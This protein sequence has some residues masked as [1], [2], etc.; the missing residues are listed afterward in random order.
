MKVH[1]SKKIND[2]HFIFISIIAI[3]ASQF[4]Q[5]F[6]FL[7]PHLLCLLSFLLIIIVIDLN[8]WMFQNLLQSDPGHRLYLQTLPN[9]ISALVC[10]VMSEVYLGRAD[11]F[12]LLEWDVSAHHVVQQDAQ[13]P[14]CGCWAV[15]PV[16]ADPFWRGVYSGTCNK[17]II[18]FHILF[19]LNYILFVSEIIHK[20]L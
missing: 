12:V 2:F 3:K 1:L 7:L 15:V 11:L 18:G 10:Q 9:K 14:H 5:I 6:F 20:A 19:A 8:P 16:Q 13:T 4:F 17:K